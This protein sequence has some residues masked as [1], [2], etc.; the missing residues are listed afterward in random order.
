MINN[1][2]LSSYYAGN[3]EKEK[4]LAT[5][6]KSFDYGFRDFSA[7]DANPAFSSIRNDPRFIA[8]VVHAKATT[9]GSTK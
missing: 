8:L 1:Y 5:L 4:A 6:Q 7:L 9:P 2:W 3:G